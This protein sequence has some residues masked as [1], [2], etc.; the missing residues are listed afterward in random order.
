MKLSIYK[1]KEELANE[2]AEWISETIESTL[3]K[4]EYFT[5]A[6]SGGETPQ[7]LY[8]K[9][10][11]PEFKEKI[12]WKRVHIFGATNGLSL[13]MMIAIMQKSPMIY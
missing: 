2:F 3:Q 9:L 5:L 10:A 12:N 1:S 13:L 8:K 6:L 4:Q 7:I 11:T